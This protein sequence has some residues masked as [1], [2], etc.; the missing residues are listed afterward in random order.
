MVALTFG[1]DLALSRLSMFFRLGRL[2][3]DRRS[4]RPVSIGSSRSWSPR[5]PIDLDRRWALAANGLRGAARGQA[6][7]AGAARSCTGLVGGSGRGSISGGH[8]S[9]RK[10]AVADRG[11]GRLNWAESAPIEVAWRRAGVLPIAVI[12]CQARNRVHRPKRTLVFTPR[13]TV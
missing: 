4:F 1:R 3:S 8:R 13:I 5:S 6:G 11:L 12:P 10:P 9:R 2:V 7:R